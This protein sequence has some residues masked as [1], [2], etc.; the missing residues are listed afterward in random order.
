M[1]IRKL[2][3]AAVA[4]AVL[5][6]AVLFSGCDLFKS[7]EDECLEKAAGLWGVLDVG[8]EQ[9]IAP[10]ASVSNPAS[11]LSVSQFMKIEDHTVTMCEG[12]DPQSLKTVWSG[13]L[14][15]DVASSG[16]V[17]FDIEGAENYVE[18]TISPKL[19]Y[20]ISSQ[21]QDPIDTSASLMSME[22]H[23][24]TEGSFVD[25]KHVLYRVTDTDDVASYALSST[26]AYIEPEIWAEQG[27]ITFYGTL[28]SFSVGEPSVANGL[29]NC[30]SMCVVY[31]DK[32]TP[33]ICVLV[34][35]GGGPDPREDTITYTP[36]EC[37][38]VYLPY[39]GIS[40]DVWA[41]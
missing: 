39:E 9:T 23:R 22:L 10:D 3:C 17:R 5:G 4:A 25:E 6:T 26:L 41:K 37:M 27:A 30:G 14:K 20:S 15:K 8:A 16:S 31:A 19:N 34:K 11:F 18:I 40:L 38:L 24:G 33:G 28:T 36:E 12:T 1:K 21:E 13:T 7:L 32:Q 29:L 2:V 35:L